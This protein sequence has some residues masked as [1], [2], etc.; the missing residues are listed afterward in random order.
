[1]RRRGLGTPVSLFA[2]QDIITSVSGI[3]IVF[4]LLLAIDLVDQQESRDE[5]VV[6]IDRQAELDQLEEKVKTLRMESVELAK[7]LEEVSR[8]DPDALRRRQAT[9]RLQIAKDSSELERLQER[10]RQDTKDAATTTERLAEL[11]KRLDMLQRQA[12]AGRAEIAE[13]RVRKRLAFAFPAGER[14]RGYLIDVSSE[15]L[16]AAPFTRSQRPEEIPR[17]LFGGSAS[18]ATW[19]KQK[20][21]GDYALF[22]VRPSGLQ[23]FRDIQKSLSAGSIAYGFDLI[24]ETDQTLDPMTGAFQP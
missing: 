23:R 17:S 6:P 12:A 24:G 20:Q 22:L 13:R 3:L 5:P 7:T 10:I 2:F 8:D 19:L 1:M 21:D 9:L 15:R 14:P 11:Q 18:I 16:L 4:T